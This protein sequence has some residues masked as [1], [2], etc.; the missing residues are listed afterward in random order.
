MAV[1]VYLATRKG[2]FILE[3]DSDRKKWNLLEPIYFGNIIY[4]F[5]PD[6]RNPSNLMIAAKTGHLG[7]TIFR[8]TDLGN[9]WKEAT[10]PPRFP[11]EYG[12]TVDFV[13]WLTPGHS[14]EPDVWYAGVT[15]QGLFRTEDGGDNW[16]IMEGH[17]NNPLI[18]KIRESSEGTPIGPLLHSINIDKNDKNHIILAH[19][20][21]GLL[22]TFDGG[23]DWKPLN[24]DVL[25]NFLPD[26]YPEWGQCIHNAQIHPADSNLIYQQ[27][28]C[29]VYKLDRRSD[30]G[31]RKWE[32]IGNNIKGD[33][34][35]EYDIGFP[36]I[37]H[38]SDVNKLWV[39]TMDSSEVWP[40]TSIDGKP[41][42]YHSKDGGSNWTR[43]SNGFPK[44]NAYFTVLR[45]ATSQDGQDPLGLYMGNKAGELWASFDE[46]NNWDCIARNLPAIYSVEVLSD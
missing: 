15:P 18:N 30:Q 19:S 45:Q 32:R 31:N 1:R 20:T 26:E 34:D 40:R 16:Q 21:G 2:A 36:L 7:P 43:Q 28:H 9:T 33:L 39:V 23:T 22:E 25:A 8:S 42:V 24:E 4:H 37:L 14:S 10:T 46:G 11:K 17:H 41:A 13:F 29:G 5:V 12:K 27:N 6:P 44:E 38:P 3:G 35:I